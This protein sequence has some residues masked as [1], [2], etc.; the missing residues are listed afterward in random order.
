MPRLSSVNGG[1]SLTV[2]LAA[3]ISALVFIAVASVLGLG[4]WSGSQNTMSL[5]NDKA[6]A[7]ITSAV[8]WVRIHLD[9]SQNQVE[10]V[11]QLIA[12]GR[13]SPAEQSRFVASLT[14]ALAAAPQ[15]SALSF[16]DVNHQSII[17]IRTPR[18]SRTVFRDD[19][20]NAPIKR[21]VAT[22]LASKRATWAAPMWLPRSKVTILNLHMP[23][24]HDGK[25]LGVLVASVT[26]RKLSS[27]LGDLEAGGAS[28]VF[29]LYDRTTVLAHPNLA[30]GAVGRSQAKPLPSLAETGDPVL[31]AIWSSKNR[32][33]LRI[34]SAGQDFQ[35]HALH[36]F[37]D[38][39]AYFYRNVSGYGSKGLQ[40]GAYF[41]T[42]EIDTELQRLKWAGLAGLATL[43]LALIT[44]IALARWIAKPIVELAGAASRIGK[45]EISETVEL[46]GSIFRELNDQA[47]SFNTMLQGLRWFETYVPKKLVS[48]LIK[49]GEVGLPASVERE[50]TVMF[51]DIV[52]FTSLSEGTSAP[53][54][55]E[56]L[57]EHFGLLAACIEEQGGTVDKFIGDSVMA[58][59]GAPDEQPDHAERAMRAAAAITTAIEIDNKRRLA[60][61]DQ[62]VHLRVGV[63]SGTVTVGNIGA[64]GRINY[65]IIGDAVN[66]G[67][68]LE[69]LG[70]KFMASNAS[71]A[72]ALVLVSQATVAQL[73]TPVPLESLGDHQLRG[74]DQTIEVFQLLPSTTS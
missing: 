5:L 56:F 40:I 31:A 24:Q 61:G 4:L 1:V 21:A 25:L 20:A 65:T 60:S 16:I 37:G 35:G 46:Q 43:I 19:S 52:G 44:A 33:P 13:I 8:D 26:V 9:A 17:N 57:N 74:R 11:E 51:T 12:Q 7:I 68:R 30:S 34:N 53:K 72:A 66:I 54:L 22:A 71:D 15:I 47:R 64:P 28:N 32:Y 36:I 67:Q 69:Q 10:F 27:Y 2:T 41:R 42:A 38:R 55:A 62:P 70:K 6:A 49:S 59:W 3:S 50:V 14:G 18:G 39:Y 29:V 73:K 63:H 23:V 45:L 58:F 48:R